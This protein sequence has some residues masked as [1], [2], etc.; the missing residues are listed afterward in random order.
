MWRKTIFLVTVLI[1]LIACGSVGNPTPA[2]QGNTS[3]E[4]SEDSGNS[5]NSHNPSNSPVLTLDS[6]ETVPPT[7]VIQEIGYFGGMGGGCGFQLCECEM[8]FHNS[9]ELVVYPETIE[10]MNVIEFQVCGLQNN[11][12]ATVTVEFP[13]QKV[14]EFIIESTPFVGEYSG[15]M[16]YFEYTPTLIT[17]PGNY[18]FIFSG[19]NWEFEQYINVVDAAGPRLYED[20]G[21]LIFYKFE[22]NEQIRLLAYRG[23]NLIGW[24]EITLDSNGSLSL[25]TSIDAGFVAIGDVSGQVFEQEK[26]EQF[27]QWSVFGGLMDVYCKDAQ[28]HIKPS[29]NVELLLGNPPLYNYD[30]GSKKITQTGKLN[31]EKGTV[32]RIDSNPICYEGSFYWQVCVDGKCGYL[33]ENENQKTYLNPTTHQV[34]ESLPNQTENIPACPGTLPTRLSVGISAEVTTNGMVPQ[35][36]LRA[37]PSLS[38]EKVHVIAAGVDIV[39]L[40]GPICAENTYWWYIHSEQGFEGW[41]REGDNEDYWIDP[42]P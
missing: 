7:D 15:N 25:Q 32:L 40:D 29:E 11:E 9:P 13:N 17:L 18:H 10:V 27:S 36:S 12:I 1:T 34:N 42:L 4:G 14:E 8:S 28:S 37:Q 19:H 2:P 26:G 3:S 22:P 30:F 6:L 20:Q 21:I 35:L 38:A 24:K 39:I 33:P 23:G 5:N 16:M 41:S 31:I